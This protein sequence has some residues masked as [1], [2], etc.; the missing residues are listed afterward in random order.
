MS[1][2]LSGDA[3]TRK[4]K[5]TYKARLNDFRHG[6]MVYASVSTGSHRATLLATCPA[7]RPALPVEA[8]TLTA[9]GG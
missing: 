1:L 8:E 5:T 9:I 2:N 3:G 4:F 6:N 7:M